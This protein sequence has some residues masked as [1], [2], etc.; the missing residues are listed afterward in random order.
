MRFLFLLLDF[1]VFFTLTA[2]IITIR[3]DVAL[4]PTVFFLENCKVMFPVFILNIILLLIFS[5]YDLNRIHKEHSNIFIEI[6]ISFIISFILSAAGIYFGATLFEVPTPKT[7]LLLILLIFYIYVLL[8]R[9]LYKSLHFSQIKIITL[10]T[11]RTLNR[12]K[13]ILRN[14][15]NYEI[16]Q[17]FNNISDIPNNLDIKNIDL[18]LVS[19]NLLNQD[20]TTTEMIFNTFISKGIK[21]LT[22]FSFFEYTFSRLSK[23]SLE[24]MTWLI[25]NIDNR[26][27][28]STYFIIK[29]LFD[30]SFSIC[31]FPVFLPVGIIIYL[32]ILLIDK[33]D[34]I[35]FQKRVG[36]KGVPIQLCKFRTFINGTETPTKLGKILRKFRLDE[37]PQLINILDGNLS[38]VGPRPLQLEDNELLNKNI[39]VHKLRNL[40]K[41]GLTGWAQLNFKA[42][43]NYS[44]EQLPTFENNFQRNIYF[45]D[46]FVR[47]AYDVWYVKNSSFLLD[48]EIMFKTAKRAFVKDKKLS[49]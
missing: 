35:F 15:N 27:Q 38:V 44:A 41:P 1:I 22:D 25:N 11:S 13:G 42:P 12:L 21:C 16:V 14:T 36:L 18:L 9:A 20:S 4:N 17:E 45:R 24:N 5:F 32:L 31:L 26:N 7:N 48:L 23:E 29:K 47:L 34:P 39:S 43:R 19:N 46:A 2:I 3:S 28:N 33:Q 6:F 37:I 40:V 8:S 49:K 30:I 10:G